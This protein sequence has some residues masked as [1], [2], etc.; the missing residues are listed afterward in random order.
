MRGRVIVRACVFIY[1]TARSGR[2]VTGKSKRAKSCCGLRWR[3]VRENT[4]VPTRTS[5]VV[6]IG[7]TRR[8]RRRRCR[9]SHTHTPAG[10]IRT[11]APRRSADG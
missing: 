3:P 6:I 7:V 1:V 9:V 2:R 4:V 5:R 10:R 8:R 11:S